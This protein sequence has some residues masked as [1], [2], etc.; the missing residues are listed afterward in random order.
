M[1]AK[2]LSKQRLVHGVGLNNADYDVVKYKTTKVNGVQ[3]RKQVW[4]CPFY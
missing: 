4:M 2:K 3:K 1:N